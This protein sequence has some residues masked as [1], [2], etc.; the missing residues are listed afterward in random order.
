[1]GIVEG[2]D[3]QAAEIARLRARVA[4]LEA[5]L[6]EVEDWA[7]RSVGAAQERLYWLD[8]WHVDLNALMRRRGASQF[9]A[10]LRAARALYRMML[11]LKRSL[12]SRA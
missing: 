12:Q 11:R 8:R 10:A 1:M 5:Q 2:E 7:N 3:D 9:R 4:D 6:I